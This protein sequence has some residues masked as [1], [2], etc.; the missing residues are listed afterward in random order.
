MTDLT[1]GKQRGLRCVA[2]ESGTFKVKVVR[3]RPPAKGLV[4]ARH[5]VALAQVLRPPW[6]PR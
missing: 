3:E 1:H 5:G 6:R 2:D 4:A